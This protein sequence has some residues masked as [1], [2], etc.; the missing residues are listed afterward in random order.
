MEW[1]NGMEWKLW[2]LCTIV[3]CLCPQ[4]GR[5]NLKHLWTRDRT[6]TLGG[7]VA[8]T[9]NRRLA[10][11]F[12][13]HQRSIEEHRCPPGLSLSLSLRIWIDAHVTQLRCSIQLIFH[14]TS[15]EVFHV[16]F[17]AFPSGIFVV[18]FP[19]GS[20]NGCLLWTRASVISA[21]TPLLFSP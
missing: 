17:I 8:F 2:S 10:G 15:F 6:W 11:G 13:V 16:H 12:Y 18:V 4:K 19:G 14:V 1:K 3:F 9:S 7:V 5:C 20:P 21:Q